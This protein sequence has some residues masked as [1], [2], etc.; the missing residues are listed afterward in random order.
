MWS[1]VNKKILLIGIMVLVAIIVIFFITR[2][3]ATRVEFGEKLSQAQ[4]AALIED[5]DPDNP[6]HVTATPE[7]VAKLNQIRADKKERELMLSMMRQMVIYKP[8]IQ[9][10]LRK[11]DMPDDLLVIPMIESKYLTNASS[12]GPG[13]PTGLW[14]ITR[15][16]AGNMDL[17]ISGPD[18]RKN[19]QLASVAA[20][21]YFRTLYGIFN[22]W[23][24]TLLAYN[25]GEGKVLS[26][27]KITGSRDV[28]VLARS[29]S[30]S[31]QSIDYLTKFSTYVIIMRNPELVGGE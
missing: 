9:G 19:V 30:A 5:S 18:E 6:F 16:T 13:L 27:I 7:V 11:Y 8:I 1:N 24:L 31:S 21:E 10:E 12:S 20:L 4:V 14:Q 23:G 2:S 25:S 28:W 15:A 26:L 29:P 22:D 17:D 3:V